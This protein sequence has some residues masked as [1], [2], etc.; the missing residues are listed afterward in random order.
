[1]FIKVIAHSQVR[2][3][4]SGAQTVV[5]IPTTGR[6][7]ATRG[8]A[9]RTSCATRTTNSFSSYELHMNFVRTPTCSDGVRMTSEPHPN[10]SSELPIRTAHPN[11]PSELPIRT[12]HRLPN[13]ETMSDSSTPL[14]AVS[15]RERRTWSLSVAS[16]RLSSTVKGGV[17]S[18]MYR[19]PA[20]SSDPRAADFEPLLSEVDGRFGWGSDGVRLHPNRWVFVRRSYEVRTN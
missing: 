18:S 4:L 14:N 3:R 15:Q 9:P 7:T 13:T 2:S 20:S 8:F 1:M 10:L 6:P 17:P 19:T 5:S 16:G 11:L 12:A